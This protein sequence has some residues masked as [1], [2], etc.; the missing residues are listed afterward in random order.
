MLPHRSPQS[1]L[2]AH[3]RI[4]H[5][6]ITL[7]PAMRRGTHQQ[8]VLGC[9]A[10]DMSVKWPREKDLQELLHKAGK[11][12]TKGVL[13]E[14]AEM[15]LEDSKEV[16][17]GFHREA[18]ALPAAFYSRM[19]PLLACIHLRGVGDVLTGPHHAAPQYYKHA[20]IILD[21]SVRKAKQSCRCNVLF[22]VSAVLRKAKSTHGSKDR[23]VKRMEPMMPHIFA[24]L[25]GCPA[26]QLV[27]PLD[28]PHA[29]ACMPY[30]ALS[31]S[32]LFIPILPMALCADDLPPTT[33][34][35]PR[36]SIPA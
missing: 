30:H 3:A 24:S 12:V 4:M 33:S 8:G 25:T 26:E 6:A 13:D 14:A 11:R 2:H 15:V 27:R 16:R 35:R 22:V 18:S 31:Y 1:S 29:H 23:L 20:A 28:A 34:P 32:S 17:D 19:Q 9:H 5:L 36:G 7:A 21:R 10:G